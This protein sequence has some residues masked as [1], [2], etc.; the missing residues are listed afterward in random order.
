MSLFVIFHCLSNYSTSR[1]KHGS[2]SNGHAA[3]AEKPYISTVDGPSWWVKFLLFSSISIDVGAT[4]GVFSLFSK[5]V[6]TLWPRAG[7]LR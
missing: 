7:F 4:T 6:S 5:W 1:I 2:F 3:A